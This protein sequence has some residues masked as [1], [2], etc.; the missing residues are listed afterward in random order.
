[1]NN[2]QRITLAAVATALSV[3]L[4][5][6][7]VQASQEETGLCKNKSGIDEYSWHDFGSQGDCYKYPDGYLNESTCVTATG[8]ISSVIGSTTTL[9]AD[10]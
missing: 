3:G 1:M 4:G 5:A 7:S 8:T 2:L 6:G 10:A 9:P